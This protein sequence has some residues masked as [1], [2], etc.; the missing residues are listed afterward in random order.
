MRRLAFILALLLA[1]PA[2]SDI[3]YVDSTSN[4]VN[5]ST[6]IDCAVPTNASQN[7]WLVVILGKDD[8]PDVTPPSGWTTVVERGTTTGAQRFIGAYIYQETTQD[9]NSGTYTFTG[10]REAWSCS[11]TT[12]QNVDGTTPLD[13]VTPTVNEETAVTTM[14]ANAVTPNTNANGPNIWGGSMC[15]GGVTAGSVTGDWTERT[16]GPVQTNIWSYSASRNIQYQTSSGSLSITGT[17]TVA[18]C[19]S[20]QFALRDG[21]PPPDPTGRTRRMF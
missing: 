9:P 6:S 16:D 5:N 15:D 12:L 2:W 8:D 17:G 11:M 3:T 20:I 1:T 19:I 21:T 7:D 4:S 18:D 10:D 13:A 14:T